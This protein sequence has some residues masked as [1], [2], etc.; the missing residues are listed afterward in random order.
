M[1]EQFLH[2]PIPSS[3]AAGIVAD[4]SAA[5]LGADSPV[6]E[7]LLEAGETL[8][9]AEAVFRPEDDVPLEPKVLMVVG[10]EAEAV[11]GGLTEVLLQGT[12][13]EGYR[14][15]KGVARH[16]DYIRTEAA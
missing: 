4:I 16:A 3:E 10:R 5:K 12:Q 8:R 7:Q 15:V 6:V 13:A 1:A 9:Q 11:W 14:T 2:L